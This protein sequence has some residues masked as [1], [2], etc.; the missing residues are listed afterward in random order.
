[1]NL[2]LCSGQNT[3][4]FFDIYEENENIRGAVEEKCM[5]CPVNRRCFAEGVSNKEWGVWGGVYFEEGEISKEF[6]EHKTPEQWQR[7]WQSLTMEA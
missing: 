3:E 5:A 1:M 6:N 4:T 7:I 2:A